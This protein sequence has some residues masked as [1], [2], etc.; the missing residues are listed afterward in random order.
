MQGEEEGSS[1][2]FFRLSQSTC[3]IYPQIRFLRSNFSS[4]SRSGFEKEDRGGGTRGDMMS[5]Y[6]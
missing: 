1:R 4:L 6:T 3:Q 5:E 2:T